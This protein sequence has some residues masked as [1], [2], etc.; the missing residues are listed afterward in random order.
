[1]YQN[2]KILLITYMRIKKITEENKK[3]IYYY[4]KYSYYDYFD[5]WKK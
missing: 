4:E 2:Q 5:S 3:I 1:M